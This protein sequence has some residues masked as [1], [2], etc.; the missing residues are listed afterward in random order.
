VDS[1]VHYVVVHGNLSVQVT[2]MHSM[3]NFLDLAQHDTDAALLVP[4]CQTHSSLSPKPIHA[5]HALLVNLP[6]RTMIS[7]VKWLAKIVNQDSPASLL[8]QLVKIVKLDSTNLTMVKPAARMIVVL[9]R[10]FLQIEA[11]VFH[12][13]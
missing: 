13:M 9:G 10:I 5:P 2:I 4:S 1:H 12:A 11:S 8:V 3:M 6:W 7:A